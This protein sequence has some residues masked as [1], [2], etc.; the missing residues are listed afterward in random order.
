MFTS[1]F[2]RSTI[3]RLAIAGMVLAAV[4]V[5]GP[6]ASAD[7]GPVPAQSYS[8][9]RPAVGNTVMFRPGE[10][11]QVVSNAY[12][13]EE[14][15]GWPVA[16][17]T[18]FT[19]TAFSLKNAPAALHPD[20]PLEVQRSWSGSN[21]SDEECYGID[22]YENTLTVTSETNC[23]NN[24]S[25]TDSYFLMNR[26]DVN[27]TVN[28]NF[29]SQV[30]KVGKKG[31]KAKAIAESNGLTTSLSGQLNVYN[32]DS[33]SL[34]TGDQN[35]YTNFEMC[36]DESLVEGGDILDVEYELTHDAASVPSSDYQIYEG[37]GGEYGAWDMTDESAVTFEIAEVP[38]Q[39]LVLGF[40]IY[41]QD[42]ETYEDT[43]ESGTYEGT[44]D[45]KLNGTSVTE[46]C[47]TYDQPAAWPTL[48][49]VDGVAGSAELTTTE[50]DTPLVLESNPN[51]DQYS[52][53]PDG[54]G[55][56]FY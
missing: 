24:L 26:S 22:E 53:R 15:S 31:K 11:G 49:T 10:E 29:S 4:T 35:L 17:N 38:D 30:V 43:T 21:W 16:T 54:F 45:V 25:V 5:S 12:V 20:Y 51:F 14:Y 8:Y 55:G 1:V 34:A 36:I 19:R 42:D 27:Q 46:P 40:T 48:S 50:R 52:S 47:P 23:I 9:T 13:S 37:N 18:V 6:T 28:T 7:S 33:V 3:A 39:N 41:M 44:V 32:E 56:M 2:S